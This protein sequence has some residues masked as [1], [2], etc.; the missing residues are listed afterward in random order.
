MTV[1]T[2]ISDSY[3]WMLTIHIL[4]AVVWVGGN[5]FI[6]FLTFRAKRADNPDG[7]LG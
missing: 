4:L 6:Q 7:W 3:K 1:A 5:V 2:V